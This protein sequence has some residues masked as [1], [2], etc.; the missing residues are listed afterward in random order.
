MKSS[1]TDLI[2]VQGILSVTA[3]DRQGNIVDHFIDGNMI[4]SVAK[5]TLAHL[6]GGDVT[7]KSVTKI[8]LGNSDTTPSPD[9]TSIGGIITTNLSSG[10]N[11]ANSI[12][13]AY[14]KTLSGH[15]YPSAGRIAFNWALDYGE[16]NGLEIR[17]YGLICSDLSMFARKTRGVITKGSDLS[18]SGVWTIIF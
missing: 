4:M 2:N 17:E 3:I 5:E 13:V 10:L 14:L 9:N 8:A 1:M 6:I 15:T 7:G 11:T 16:A 12:S 18:V